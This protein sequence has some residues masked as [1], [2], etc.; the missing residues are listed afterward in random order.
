MAHYT[1]LVCLAAPLLDEPAAC[2]DVVQEAFQRPPH[3]LQ[4]QG[5]GRLPQ[6]L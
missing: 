2:E 1:G 4:R 5:T 6:A 3:L